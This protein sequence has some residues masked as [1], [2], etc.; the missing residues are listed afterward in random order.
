MP[1][2]FHLDENM[3]GAVADGLRRRG[4]DVST[5]RENRQIGATDEVQ[6][7]FAYSQRRAIVTRDQGFLCLH[8]ERVEHSGI[9][10]WTER[11]PIGK[12]IVALDLLATESAPEDL[13]QRIVYL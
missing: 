7:A 10:F 6:L 4:V 12:L 1:V 2:R 11:R 3:P 8:D 9:I 13:R 5:S